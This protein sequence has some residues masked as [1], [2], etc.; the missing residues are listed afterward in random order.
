M[1]HHTLYS[2]NLGSK[3]SALKS[4]YIRAIISAMPRCRRLA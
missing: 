3:E 1:I 4:C 2:I